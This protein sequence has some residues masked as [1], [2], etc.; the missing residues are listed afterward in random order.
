MI[1]SAQRLGK[2]QSITFEARLTT[3]DQ[4]IACYVACEEIGKTQSNHAMVLVAE[5][6]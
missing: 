6:L 2:A 1:C 4:T 5:L 3:P